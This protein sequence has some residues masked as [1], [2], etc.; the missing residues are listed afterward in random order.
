MAARLRRCLGTVALTIVLA[1]CAGAP[2]PAPD[3]TVPTARLVAATPGEAL[4]ALIAAIEEQAERSSHP[5]VRR[6]VAEAVARIERGSVSIDVVD[7]PD[8]RLI[9]GANLEHDPTGVHAPL[10]RVDQ[11][12]LA[13]FESQP[14]LAMAVIVHEM[15]HIHDYFVHPHTFRAVHPGSLEHFSFEMDAH[16][17]EALFVLDRQRSGVADRSRYEELLVASLERDDLASVA[18]LMR[19]TD[20]A[21]VYHYRRHVEGAIG[22][23]ARRSARRRFVDHGRAL[24]ARRPDRA[25]RWDTYRWH[26]ELVTWERL[27]ARLLSLQTPVAAEGEPWVAETERVRAA[28]RATAGVAWEEQLAYRR[29]TVRRLEQPVTPN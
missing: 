26:V 25:H 28:A 4:S 20:L 3:F 27:A 7:W 8:R 2:H 9:G 12:L 10:L 5:H 24:L 18:A 22:E 29:A 17:T 16:Y 23:D 13:A 6:T 15:R 14:G 19:A 21:L 11:D 1:T